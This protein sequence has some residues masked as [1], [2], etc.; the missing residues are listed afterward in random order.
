MRILG[1]L[2]SRRS[3]ASLRRDALLTS[4]ATPFLSA[5]VISRLQPGWRLYFAA[6]T[7]TRGGEYT[8]A[9]SGLRGAAAPPS[10]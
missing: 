9:T 4:H 3:L 6:T 8:S 5:V 2:A 7:V 10:P 1:L